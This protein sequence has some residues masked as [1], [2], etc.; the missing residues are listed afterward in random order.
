M[1]MSE[2][3]KKILREKGREDLIEIMEIN[4]SGY[5]GVLS[6]GNIVDRRIHPDAIPVQENKMM[7][8]PKP[9]SIEK[10]V[11]PDCSGCGQGH[12]EGTTCRRCKGKGEVLPED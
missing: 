7:G 12:A 2:E 1:P 5:A 10:E 6:N 11:C 8:I 9:K 4:D 3:T